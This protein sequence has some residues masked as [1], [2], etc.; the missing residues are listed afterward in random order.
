MLQTIYL[1]TRLIELGFNQLPDKYKSPK[2]RTKLKREYLLS[3]TPS[4][5]FTAEDVENYRSQLGC[6]QE[7]VDKE[8]KVGDENSI[9][10][11]MIRLEG[12][13]TRYARPKLPEGG[14]AE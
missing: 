11:N 12:F 13:H 14:H 7:Y 9:E 2:R 10:G 1:D 3:L 6:I 5:K 4:I 8:F